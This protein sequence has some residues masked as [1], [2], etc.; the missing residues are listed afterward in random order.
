MSGPQN[1]MPAGWDEVRRWRRA[2][3][4]RLLSRRLAIPLSERERVRAGMTGF[5]LDAAAAQG[6]GCVGFYWPIKREIDLRH[7]ARHFL[8]RGSTAALP[9]VVRP[10]APLEFWAWLPRMKL[11]RGVWEIPVPDSRQVV[12]PTLLLVP[13]LGFDDA[14]HR[15]GYGDGYY[16][17]SL[18]AIRPK[19]FT[20]GVG[21]ERGRIDTIFPQAHDVP[22][23]AIVTEAGLVWHRSVAAAVADRP[24]GPELAQSPGLAIVG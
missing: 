17:R 2:T 6:P 3:R 7:L 24:I 10:A 4:A 5:V 18:A 16:D 9:V 15:L 22:M 11:R 21:Y 14:G 1:A 23:D 12:V 19:P 8:A 20:I 13:L